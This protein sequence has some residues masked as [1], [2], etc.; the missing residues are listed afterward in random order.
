VETGGLFPWSKRIVV[1]HQRI[2]GGHERRNNNR[3]ADSTVRIQ[4]K[5]N[6]LHVACLSVEHNGIANAWYVH[7]IGRNWLQLGVDKS[8]GLHF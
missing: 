1:L 8:N 2:A 4:E 3:D 6:G 5:A 7:V